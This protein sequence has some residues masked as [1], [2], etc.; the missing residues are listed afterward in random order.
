MWLP[1]WCIYLVY[2]NN[3]VCL[4]NKNFKN[5]KSTTFLKLK[6][7]DKKTGGFFFTWDIILLRSRGINSKYNVRFHYTLQSFDIFLPSHQISDNHFLA[8]FNLYLYCMII[9][10]FKHENQT[11]F[12][13]KHQIRDAASGW[14][15]NYRYYYLCVKSLI[16][17]KIHPRLD[18]VNVVIRP[19][20]FIKSSQFTK[21]SLDKE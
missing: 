13:G 12:L 6:S 17:R 1:C 11:N 19:L 14:W 15:H 5:V 20:L 10:I 2:N 3:R 21:S 9:E 16:R 4:M 18:L 7:I 8:S